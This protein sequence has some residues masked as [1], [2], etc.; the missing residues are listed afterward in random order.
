MGCKK[1]GAK[2]RFIVTQKEND[3]DSY[4]KPSLFCYVIRKIRKMLPKLSTNKMGRVVLFFFLQN[5]IN[6]EL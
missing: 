2:N 5:L 6:Y 4:C 3:F 1:Q